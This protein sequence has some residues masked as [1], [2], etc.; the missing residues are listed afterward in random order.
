MK[1]IFDTD[2]HWDGLAL[3]LGLG[4]MMFPHG[5]GKLLGWFGGS[6]YSATMNAMTEGMGVPAI[7]ALAA[8]LTEFFG[9][10]ALLLGLATRVAALGVGFTMLVASYFHWEHGFFMNW[11]G[12]K[13]GEGFEF[14]LLAVAIATALVMKG[15]GALGLDRLIQHQSKRGKD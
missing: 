4:L 14:H 15:S 2:A 1:R 9:G 5:A 6:G 13:S 11:Y 7:F 10:F 12:T 8:I 3:R